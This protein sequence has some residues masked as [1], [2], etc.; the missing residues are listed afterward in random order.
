MCI[1]IL[2]A[3]AKQCKLWAAVVALLQTVNVL[4]FQLVARQTHVCAQWC[5]CVCVCVLTPCRAVN[6]ISNSFGRIKCL[7]KINIQLE[8]QDKTRQDDDDDGD[9][10]QLLNR[11]RRHSAGAATVMLTVIVTTTTTTTA[12]LIANQMKHGIKLIVRAE[13]KT[14]DLGNKRDATRRSATRHDSPIGMFCSD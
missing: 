8:P 3:A 7:H 11:F 2:P 4:T 14:K 9:Q 10:L 1:F 13:N 12:M 5:V 6:F